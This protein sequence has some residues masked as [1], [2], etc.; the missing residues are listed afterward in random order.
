MNGQGVNRALE[1]FRQQSV[2][3]PVAREKLLALELLGD[4][5]DL[6]MSFR[7]RRNIV[8]SAFVDDVEMERRQARAQFRLETLLNAHGDAHDLQIGSRLRPRPAAT[9]HWQIRVGDGRRA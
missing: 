5:E 4:D 1:L 7:A 2:D 6:E 9:W 8:H 3:P